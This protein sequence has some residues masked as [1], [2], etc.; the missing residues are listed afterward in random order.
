MSL[1]NRIL[2]IRY[3]LRAN[4]FLDNMNTELKLKNHSDKLCIDW[5][6]N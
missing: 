1:L 6:K 2:V 4:F 3:S 5:V